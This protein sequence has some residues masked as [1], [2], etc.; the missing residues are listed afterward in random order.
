[1]KQYKLQKLNHAKTHLFKEDGHPVQKGDV[2]EGPMLA[3]PKIGY[4]VL[5]YDSKDNSRAIQTSTVKHIMV[6]DHPTRCDKLVIPN[7]FPKEELNGLS[8]DLQK[9]DVLFVTKNSLYLL[10]ELL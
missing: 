9:N 6:V 3:S 1:M 5:V 7:E 8:L 10:R 4:S 2:V